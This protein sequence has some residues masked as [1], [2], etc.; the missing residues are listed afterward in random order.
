MTGRAVAV[1][2][3]GGRGERL[4]GCDKAGIVLAGKSLIERACD[5]L[6]HQADLILISRRTPERDWPLPAGT[7]E[8]FD[9]PGDFGGPLAGIGSALAHID[10]ESLEADFLLS[11]AVD[12]PLFPLDFAA[13]AR[14]DLQEQAGIGLYDGQ[15]YPT[16]GLW[17][18]GALA[19][20]PA[21]IEAR[22]SPKGPKAL[23]ETL[24]WKKVDWFPQAD[25]NP[26]DNAN[27]LEDLNNLERRV[28]K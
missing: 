24:V 2:L 25:G 21:R 16:N 20:L 8:I 27:T 18:V 12:S 10:K 28:E 22:D 5:R 19:E 7:V 14:P 15:V 3:A 9:L 1:I 17:R 26:F 23:L 4:G 11:M 13:R 6:R